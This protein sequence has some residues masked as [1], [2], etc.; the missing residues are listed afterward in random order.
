MSPAIQAAAI[1][2]HCRHRFNSI[3]LSP[4]LG[5][6]RFGF[7]LL[8][9][10]PFRSCCSSFCS[11]FRCCCS[12]MLFAFFRSS[13]MANANRNG[14]G[15]AKANSNANGYG[16]CERQAGGRGSGEWNVKRSD[17]SPLWALSVLT[18]I[19]QNVASKRTKSKRIEHVA[20]NVC[21]KISW[22]YECANRHLPAKMLSP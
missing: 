3:L 7:G 5:W 8:R 22:L 14:N 6:I 20:C 17:A 1:K 16:N 9:F 4:R 11:F 13:A 15:N 2:L 10:A 19:G 21:N 18:N 12:S